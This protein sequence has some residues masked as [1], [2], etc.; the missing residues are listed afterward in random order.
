MIYAE[1]LDMVI[2]DIDCRPSRVRLH[3]QG[4]EVGSRINAMD[5]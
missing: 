3:M 4:A 2:A 5:F 1:Q